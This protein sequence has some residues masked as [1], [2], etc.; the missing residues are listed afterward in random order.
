MK[1]CTICN[2]EKDADSFHGISRKVCKT[3]V[4]Q[5]K[6]DKQK[7]FIEN[8]ANITRTCKEC[9]EE[10]DGTHYRFDTYKC[11][12][13][14][15]RISNRATNKPTED[16]PDKTCSKC[17]TI[18]SATSFRFRTNVCIECEKQDMY[19]WR[20]N[21]PDK[22]K[23]HLTKYRSTDKYKMSKNEYRRQTYASN[24]HEKVSRLCRTRIREAL[25][26]TS[27][28]TNSFTLIG[29]SIEQLKAWLEYNFTNEMTWDN[30]GTC[31][32]IDHIR[33]CASFDLAIEDQQK[34]C[35]N[36]KNMAPLR[37]EENLSK[38]ASINEWMIKYYD[39]RVKSFISQ[40]EY[41]IATSPN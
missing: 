26:G 40:Y 3:C 15:A 5:T 8:A 29:C 28:V 1:M 27:K 23:E 35:F 6:K 39:E 14:I 2:L 4:A 30:L 12:E 11:K 41:P 33:P 18:K 7:A 9:K 36:W 13:C 25:K 31:W 17:S 16:M 21:N 24:V 38:G 32:H 19:Q 34:E 20:K 22:F 37:K 10:K